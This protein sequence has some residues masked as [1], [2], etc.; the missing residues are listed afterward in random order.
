MNAL[1]PYQPSGSKPDSQVELTYLPRRSRTALGTKAVK[2]LG[3]FLM[4]Q[5]V[6]FVP[7][8][9]VL[10]IISFVLGT[11]WQIGLDKSIA[12]FPQNP[13]TLGWIAAFNAGCWLP[14]AL[15][16]V[17]SRR[18]RSVNPV[19]NGIVGSG[20]FAVGMIIVALTQVAIPD[21]NNWFRGLPIYL[22]VLLVGS[23]SFVAVVVLSRFGTKE[24]L[25]I[26]TQH[27]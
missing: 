5:F 6:T 21:T 15:F 9:F 25:E 2:Q 23:P 11:A 17:V 3:S 16:A 22:L 24:T 18:I 13:S 10:H 20:F 1:N 19:L 14:H 26:N 8:L 4:I 27:S 12:Y 7:T